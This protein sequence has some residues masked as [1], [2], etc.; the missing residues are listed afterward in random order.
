VPEPGVTEDVTAN[1]VDL[2][3]ESSRRDLGSTPTNLVPISNAASPM[4]DNDSDL[5][6]YE[7]IPSDNG[8]ESSIQLPDT[9]ITGECND[10][11]NARQGRR[12]KQVIVRDGVIVLIE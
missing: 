10:T 1:D 11:G 8:V 6:N 4:S 9:R 12:K 2:E 5:K 3:S 7:I